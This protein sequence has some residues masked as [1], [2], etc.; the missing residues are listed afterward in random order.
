MARRRPSCAIK[1]QSVLQFRRDKAGNTHA[2]A[3]VSKR[4]I[5]AALRY[6]QSLRCRPNSARL[7]N[8]PLYPGSYFSRQRGR[9]L[10]GSSLLFFLLFNLLGKFPLQTS[11][12]VSLPPVATAQDYVAADCPFCTDVLLAQ[13]AKPN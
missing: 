10:F 12:D 8:F 7:I 5:F 3:Q 1:K 4:R 6:S 2:F 13:E 9:C 11:L